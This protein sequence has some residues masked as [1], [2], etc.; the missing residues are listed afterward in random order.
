[1]VRSLVVGGLVALGVGAPVARADEID[2]STFEGRDRTK[3]V[4]AALSATCA[5]LEAPGDRDACIA[6]CEQGATLV[7]RAA[8]FAV[9][10]GSGRCSTHRSV[11]FAR[12]GRW[13]AP[14]GLEIEDQSGHAG[15]LTTSEVV[16]VRGRVRGTSARAA[17]SIRSRDLPDCTVECGPPAKAVESTTL[18]YRCSLDATPSCT[19][20]L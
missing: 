10:R 15:T 19:L 18:E 8:P 17:L 11:V 2:V 5:T 14:R 4:A 3:V 12:A 20:R 7:L 9:Y 16:A 6:S 1:M 13:F